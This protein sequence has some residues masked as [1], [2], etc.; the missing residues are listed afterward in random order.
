MH[1]Y[2]HFNQNII[3]FK[4]VTLYPGVRNSKCY[5]IL[6]CGVPLFIL[7]YFLT[8]N[9]LLIKMVVILFLSL[10]V[11]FYTQ[12]R[13]SANIKED[14]MMRTV[15]LLIKSFVSME[16]ALR[17]SVT[18]LDRCRK[19]TKIPFKNTRLCR[20]IESKSILNKTYFCLKKFFYKQLFPKQQ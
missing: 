6:I 11:Y 16:L 13:F 14:T 2:F 7:F 4:K 12:A 17:C 15:R 8:Q 18:G 9:I 1:I 5:S 3:H 19:C 10:I 20:I